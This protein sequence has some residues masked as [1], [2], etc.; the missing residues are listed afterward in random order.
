MHIYALC[1]YVPQANSTNEDAICRTRIRSQLTYIYIYIIHSQFAVLWTYKQLIYTLHRSTRDGQLSTQTSGSFGDSLAFSLQC[2]ATS[3]LRYEKG[4]GSSVK[5]FIS[6]YLLA[7][8]LPDATSASNSV[9]YFM[10]H[11]KYIK[12]I[13]LH[14]YIWNYSYQNVISYKYNIV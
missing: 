3:R 14:Q 5:C 12:L 13:N 8:W 1:H 7:L 10:L 9:C 6:W 2:L 4:L 11:K